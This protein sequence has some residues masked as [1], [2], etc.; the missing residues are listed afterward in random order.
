M[1]ISNYEFNRKGIDFSYTYIIHL[2]TLSLKFPPEMHISVELM[3]EIFDAL[4]VFE[5]GPI[6]RKAFY[7]LQ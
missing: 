3:L 4:V 1:K 5:N 6:M 2:M 7:F